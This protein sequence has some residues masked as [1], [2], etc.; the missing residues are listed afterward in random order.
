MPELVQEILKAGIFGW[1]PGV[2]T[3]SKRIG[4]PDAFHGGT[5]VPVEGEGGKVRINNQL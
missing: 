4:T 1:R 3:V 5:D 2:G